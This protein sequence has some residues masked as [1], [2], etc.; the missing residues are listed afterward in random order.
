MSESTPVA[1]PET[2]PG[3][4]P[5]PHVVEFRGVGKTFG[6]GPRAFTAI[7]DYTD[8]D[9]RTHHTNA[10]LAERV[11]GRDLVQSAVVMASMAWLAAN[12][13]ERV[14]RR[15]AGP[16]STL[17]RWG[18]LVGDLTNLDPVVGARVSLEGTNH[19]GT[20]NERG[21]LVL[22]GVTAGRFTI[23][24]E[25]PDYAPYRFENALVRAGRLTFTNYWMQPIPTR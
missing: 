25:H 23:V 8:Y 2:A 12:A 16:P 21:E 22:D 18:A 15:P 9:T 7:K 24:I 5:A 4:V 19:T 20:T 13:D 11:Q 14:P 3:A 1:A 17:G 10:D 6:D